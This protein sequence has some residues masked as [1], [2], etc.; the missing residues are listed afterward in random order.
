MANGSIWNL[1]FKGAAT[2]PGTTIRGG[3]QSRS[4]LCSLNTAGRATMSQVLTRAIMEIVR[5]NVNVGVMAGD[6]LYAECKSTQAG[7]V[8]SLV[9]DK[10]GGKLETFVTSNGTQ[11]PS[12]LLHGN[13]FASWPV[14]IPRIIQLLQEGV[15]EFV[16]AFNVIQRAFNTN[17]VV[18][19]QNEMMLLND[20][21]YCSRHNYLTL[22]TQI[23]SISKAN[24]AIERDLSAE[25]GGDG[26]FVCA[27]ALNQRSRQSAAQTQQA[28]PKTRNQRSRSNAQASSNTPYYTGMFELPWKKGELSKEDAALIP[29]LDLSALKMNPLVLNSARIIQAEHEAAVPVE[30]L[31]FFGEAGGGK[32]TGAK[33]LAQLLGVPYRFMVCSK[34]TEEGDFTGEFQPEEG[35]NTFKHAEPPFMATFLRGGVIE[36][37]EPNAAPPNVLIHLNSAMDETRSVIVRKSQQVKRHRNCIIVVTSNVG[38]SGTRDMNEAWKDRFQRSCEF[39]KMGVSDMID[40]VV[41]GSGNQDVT[42]IK[43]MIDAVDKICKKMEEEQLTGGVCGTRQLINWAREAKY[44]TPLEAAKVTI[45]PGISQIKEVMDDYNDKILKNMF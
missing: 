28:A 29:N 3:E 16:D 35:K 38:Y 14:F 5:G 40:I 23:K 4:V 1:I 31:N 27:S 11:D 39:T 10:V 36:I 2:I 34:N 30:N 19:E 42:T 33:I 6:M 41:R 12:V 20:Y 22:T 9:Y 24:F 37:M 44:A 8:Y 17:G 18:T 13:N 21:L 25:Y 7:R 45:L 26:Q 43:K 32:S 15:Q